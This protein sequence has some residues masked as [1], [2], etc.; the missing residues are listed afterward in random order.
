MTDDFPINPFAINPNA[1][2]QVLR[3][4]QEGA[5]VL[6]IDDLLLN[7]DALFKNA[8]NQNFEPPSGTYYPGLNAP[9]PEQYLQNL[10][11]AIR[12]SIYRAFEIGQEYKIETSGFFALTTIG[13][14]DFGPWQKIPHYDL[15]FDGHFALVHYMAQ[16]Q[17]GGTGFFRHLP[18]GFEIINN[19]RREKYLGQITNWI[20]ENGKNLIDFAGEK[21]PQ[22]E[23]FFKVPFKY[24]RA[25]LYPANILHCAL[26][27][28]TNQNSN[29]KIGRLTANSFWAVQ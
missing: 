27:D 23:M 16:N 20:E 3:I 18:T 6:I 14:D 29:P 22:F 8:Q 24:N 13:L 1:K 10:G 21:T 25:I 15:T 4:G 5:P 26:Y 19:E 28:G 17:T 12:P 11:R 7:P 2:V 9:L